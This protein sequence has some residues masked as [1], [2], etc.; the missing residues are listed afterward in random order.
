MSFLTGKQ[1]EFDISIGTEQNIG[2][3]A[4]E[5]GEDGPE[6]CVFKA[7]KKMLMKDYKNDGCFVQFYLNYMLEGN[8]EQNKLMFLT[9]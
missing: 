6:D 8:R 1:L 3:A 7:V 5:H 4:K 9:W 2:E